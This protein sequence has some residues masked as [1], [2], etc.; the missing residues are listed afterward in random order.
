MDRAG[1]TQLDY[2]KAAAT[3]RELPKQGA[4]VIE[5]TPDNPLVTF[6]VLPRGDVFMVRPAITRAVWDDDGSP[7]PE[8]AVWSGGRVDAEMPLKLHKIKKVI[9]QQASYTVQ[10]PPAV[11]DL[12]VEGLWHSA[13]WML[14]SLPADTILAMY[15]LLNKDF[16]PRMEELARPWRA[17]TVEP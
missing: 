9:V 2:I 7:E 1:R 11:R 4:R 13:I 16:V 5:I 10:F 17:G 8:E 14:A 12:V 3:Y 6:G 15:A